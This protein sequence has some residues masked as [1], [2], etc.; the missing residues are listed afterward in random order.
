M[1]FSLTNS[2]AYPALSLSASGLSGDT[3]LTTMELWFDGATINIEPTIKITKSQILQSF[4]SLGISI[5]TP[6][7][8]FLLSTYHLNR[9]AFVIHVLNT[10]KTSPI[11]RTEAIWVKTEAGVK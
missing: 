7:L 2:I 11:S 4:K 1:N 3:L 9:P 10:S 6:A 8:A 5:Q